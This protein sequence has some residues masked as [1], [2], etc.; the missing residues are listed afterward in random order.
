[1]VAGGEAIE[2]SIPLEREPLPKRVLDVVFGCLLLL[3]TAP[4]WPLIALAVKLEDGGPVF[5]RQRRWGQGGRLFEVF[6]FRTMISDSDEKHGVVEARD[7]DERVTRVG[8]ILRSFGIDELP[9]VLNIVKGEMSF[10]GPRPLAVGEVVHDDDGNPTVWDRLPE[11]RRRM[12]VRPGLT[13]LA[14]LYLPKD[15]ERRR[16]FRYDLL[17]IRRRSFW[18]DVRLIALSLWVSVSGRWETRQNKI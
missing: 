15:V 6:K 4:A 16:K 12:S 7:E 17:Y 8:A 11:F 2:P 10:V 18:L 1:M 13:S 9:Q 14:T 5:Y 3:A